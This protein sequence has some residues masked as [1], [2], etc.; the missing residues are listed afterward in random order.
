MD[1]QTEDI[2]VSIGWKRVNPLVN[3][4]PREKDGKTEVT[5]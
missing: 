2:C 3:A 5:R 4:K 1:E